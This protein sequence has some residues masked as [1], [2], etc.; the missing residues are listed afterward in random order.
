MKEKQDLFYSSDM[1]EVGSRDWQKL[2]SHGFKDIPQLHGF[3]LIETFSN[4]ESIRLKVRDMESKGAKILSLESTPCW[5]SRKWQVIIQY[6][7][8]GNVPLQ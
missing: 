8:M 1:P 2:P 6:E 5:E 3:W 4:T 7:I